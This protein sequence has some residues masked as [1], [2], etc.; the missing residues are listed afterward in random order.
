[1]TDTS[2]DEC[3]NCG[4]EADYVCKALKEC[5]LKIYKIVRQP[6]AEKIISQYNPL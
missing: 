3:P 1:M 4:E 6:L 5:K 2:S